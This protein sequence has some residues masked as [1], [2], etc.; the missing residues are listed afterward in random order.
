MNRKATPVWLRAEEGVRGL[1]SPECLSGWIC[2]LR[3]SGRGEPQHPQ[4]SAKPF[5]G[6]QAFLTAGTAGVAV[7]DLGKQAQRGHWSEGGT[8]Q[9]V[10]LR[11]QRQGGRGHRH[12]QQSQ[13]GNHG[14]LTHTDLQRG[15]ST[16]FPEVKFIGS[17]LNSYLIC[18]NRKVPG[19]VNKV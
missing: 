19:Q 5:S 15:L 7:V 12:A 11:R 6:R 8:G 18:I 16:V 10:A 14:S 3:P 1:G 2:H 4:S 17:Q 9:A 13:D